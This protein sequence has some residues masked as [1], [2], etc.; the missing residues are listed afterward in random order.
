MDR[1]SQR[2]ERRGWILP[3][4]AAAMLLLAMDA[5]I[6]SGRGLPDRIYIKT[7]TETFT[8]RYSFA[9]LDG[10]IYYRPNTGSGGWLLFP[11][12]GLPG[13]SG[14]LGFPPPRRVVRIS[15]D[16][17]NLIAQGDDDVVY[18]AKLHDFTWT[19]RWGLVPKGHLVV[20]EGVLALAISHRGRGGAKYYE[21]RFGQQHAM[22]AG[23]TTLYLLRS[24]GDRCLYADPWLPPVFGHHLCLPLR[25]RFVAA[26]LAASASTVFV[27]GAG[28]EMYTRLYDYDTAG[29]NPLLPYTYERL[30]L[31]PTGLR[32]KRALPAEDWRR[33]PRINGRITDAITIVQNGEGNAARELRVEGIDRSGSSGYYRKPVLQGAWEFVKTGHR[34]RGRMLSSAAAPPGPR[35]TGDYSGA[36]RCTCGTWSGTAELLDF[37]FLCEGGTVRIVSGD[38]IVDIPLFLR[39]SRRGAK[40]GFRATGTLAAP[41]AA[42]AGST[43][44]A[45]FGTEGCVT[46]EVRGD[47]D[48]VRITAPCFQ[49]SFRRKR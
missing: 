7:A 40:G 48:A 28:G 31:R 20:P 45:L 16:G 42:S 13:R 29:E 46:A 25:G 35:I 32:N 9:I 30:P 26:N 3:A 10:K 43:T 44:S 6:P 34:L 18:Y 17:D 41:A 11:P 21:D 22:S 47:E 23:V 38:T 27:I 5:G 33:Q 19:D 1:H 14:I 12:G 39:R 2:A 49:M 37:S 4:I 24:Q 36:V 8:S 15:A